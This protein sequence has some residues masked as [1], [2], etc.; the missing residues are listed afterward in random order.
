MRPNLTGNSS[1]SELSRIIDEWAIDIAEEFQI[2]AEMIPRLDFTKIKGCRRWIKTF[3]D[4]EESV[5]RILAWRAWG[6][7]QGATRLDITHS[8]LGDWLRR[9]KLT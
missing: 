9:R 5:T 4:I 3:D 8:A 6:M 2:D 1:R 7:T